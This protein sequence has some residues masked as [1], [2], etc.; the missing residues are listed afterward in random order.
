[1][2]GLLVLLLAKFNHL[3][4]NEWGEINKIDI[5][6]PRDIVDVII[7]IAGRLHEFKRM[8]G[9]FNQSIQQARGMT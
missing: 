4:L 7:G 5:G 9:L 3:L 1:M 6:L 2:D 8:A